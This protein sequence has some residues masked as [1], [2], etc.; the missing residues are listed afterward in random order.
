MHVD[1]WAV[2]VGHRRGATVMLLGHPEAASAS[3]RFEVEGA[4]AGGVAALA[5]WYNASCGR[6]NRAE[7]LAVWPGLQQ[8][9]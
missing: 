1:R 7:G 8:A 5:G 6:V 4:G 3:G 9:S 2:A